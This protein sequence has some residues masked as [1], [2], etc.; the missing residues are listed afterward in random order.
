[1]GPRDL[2][3]IAADVL[4]RLETS[5]FVSGSVASSIYG[6]YRSTLDVDIVID[7][8]LGK[9]SDLAESFPDSEYY[10]SV[11]AI[12]QALEDASQFNV[13]H[14]PSGLKIDFMVPDIDAFTRL[15]F[16]RARS[17]EIAPGRPVRVSAPEDVI[18]KKLEYFKMGGSDK[19]LRDI[20]SMIRVS[21]ETFD[22]AY[23]ERWADT[24]GVREEWDAV[25]ARVG[26]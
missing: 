19:H 18:L 4:D 13:I 24:L 22:R 17:I 14:A 6:E 26:W 10:V 5:Y 3:L 8:R 16:E 25:K 9:I 12:R 15:R 21:G 7:L 23:L 2:L 20:A 11:P 1:V